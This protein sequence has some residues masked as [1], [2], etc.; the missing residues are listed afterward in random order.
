M[1]RAL[2]IAMSG[3]KQNTVSQT[4]HSNNLANASTTGFRSDY[5]QSRA[6]P[7]FGD[8]FPTRAFAMAERP[9][10]DLRQ[11][12]LQETGRSLDVTIEGAG[13]FVV[14]GAD[15]E[16]AYT[17]AG[18]LSVDP[19]GRLINGRGLQLLSDGGPA[20]IPPFETIE[21]AR[22]GTISIRAQG[23]G[24]EAV[25]EVLQIRMVNPDSQSLEKGTD[26]L[27]RI[28]GR[29]PGDP[30]AEI[31]PNMSLVSGFIEGS[32]VNAVT[33]L[34]QVLAMNRQYEMQVKLMK[35]ADEN[36]AATTQL[37]SAQ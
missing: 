31:D 22:D 27:F 34:T 5:T 8:H 29:Q 23:E 33:E 28:R 4:A 13:W 25:A 2:Y 37:L 3:A 32:N 36:S 14:E 19:E 10:S 1:D 20:V 18:D 24:S 30:G 26:G 9:A 17:R 11:G 15:G 16:E 21:I 35:T 6:M 12:P 7:V